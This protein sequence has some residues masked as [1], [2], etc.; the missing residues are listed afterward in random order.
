MKTTLLVMCIALA[1]CAATPEK[2]ESVGQTEAARLAPPAK[3][4]SSYANYQLMPMVLGPAVQS[5][6]RKVEEAEKLDTKLREKLEPLIEQWQA[7][8]PD[9]RSGTL[10]IEPQLAALRIVSG[11]ARFWAGGL[12]GNSTIDLDLL[13]TDQASGQ[14][15]AKPR[16]AREADAI[17]GGWSIGK[18]DQNLHDYI[19]S[20]AYQYLTDNY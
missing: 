9:G 19:V 16:I 20:I 12:A 14:Q 18:S 4:F 5:E 11:G 15:V 7:A 6:S 8:P 13:F 3:S 2:L 10:L 17:S 1:G